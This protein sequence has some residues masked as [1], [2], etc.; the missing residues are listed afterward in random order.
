MD[1]PFGALGSTV[2]SSNSPP[3]LSKSSK[4]GIL[5][6]IMNGEVVYISVYG[7][8]NTDLTPVFLGFSKQNCQIGK[9]NLLLPIA[10]GLDGNL[11]QA[12]EYRINADKNQDTGETTLQFTNFKTGRNISVVKS[13][14][15]NFLAEGAIPAIFTLDQ[16]TFSNWSTTDNNVVA[17][18]FVNYNLNLKSGGELSLC[19]AEKC[20]ASECVSDGSDVPIGPIVL[21]PKKW[22]KDC[23]GGEGQ[24]ESN[25]KASFCSILCAYTDLRANKSTFKFFGCDRTEKSCT[26]SCFCMD[27]PLLGFTDTTDCQNGFRYEYCK[28][29]DKCSGSCQSACSEDN[30]VCIFTESSTAKLLGGKSG[31]YTCVATGTTGTH[32]GTGCFLDLDCCPEGPIGCDQV[33]VNRKCQKRTIPK[34]KREMIIIIG[35][36]LGV[37]VLGVIIFVVYLYSKKKK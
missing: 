9:D 15:S 22:F 25:V 3:D 19:R 35:S 26:G 30:Q 6:P 2:L 5:G 14:N 32:S 27:E 10:N 8:V 17:L 13:G 18:S 23:D 21:V 12:N 11:D 34:K 28:I 20:N 1:L 31:I 7:G 33:C 29:P 37:L 24:S 16:T 36:V 4:A